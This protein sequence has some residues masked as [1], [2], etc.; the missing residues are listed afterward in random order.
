MQ[1]GHEY[2]LKNQTSAAGWGSLS[3]DGKSDDD[4][5]FLA[6]TK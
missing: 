2:Y 4:Q 3:N 1:K 6:T 5:K